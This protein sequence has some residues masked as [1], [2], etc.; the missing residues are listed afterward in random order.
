MSCCSSGATGWRPTCLYRGGGRANEPDLLAL[1]AAAL[2]S[3]P[4][5]S[6]VGAGAV[7]GV[8][9]PGPADWTSGDA[10]EA[11]AEAVVERRGA[12]GRDPGGAGGVALFR[13]RPS[14]GVGAAAL[15]GGADVQGAPAAADARGEAAGADARRP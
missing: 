12:A 8:S 1:H 15:A 3:G 6:G 4:G 7:D 13:G 9:R 2:W 14:Q 10:P 11:R 5:V